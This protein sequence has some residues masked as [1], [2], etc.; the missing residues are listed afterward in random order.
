MSSL[1]NPP[2]APSPVPVVNP[3]DTANRIN[4]ALMRQLQSGGTNADLMGATPG[5]APQAR[6]PTLTG[7]G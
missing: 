5:A 7:I 4:G 6:G 1:F 3:G 2:K